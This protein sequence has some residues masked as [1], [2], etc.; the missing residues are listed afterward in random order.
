MNLN[1]I[2]FCREMN[3][4]ND[5]T[6]EQATVECDDYDEPVRKKVK[7]EEPIIQ[8]VEKVLCYRSDLAF[9]Y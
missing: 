8:V 6:I 5:V 1:L 3:Q 7:V 4:S 9:L 2:I